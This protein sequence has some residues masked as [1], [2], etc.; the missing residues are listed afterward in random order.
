M[1]ENVRCMDCSKIIDLSNKKGME[2][3]PV[4]KKEEKIA[5]LN[6]LIKNNN[7]KNIHSCICAN[8]LHEYILLMKSKT[9]EEKKRHNNYMVSM[10]DLLLDISD[11][12]NI[13]GVLKV[14]LNE[15]EI[16]EL[17]KQN[18]KLKNERIEMEEIINK[19][20]QELKELRD[21]EENICVKINKILKEKEENKEINN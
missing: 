3:I 12:E 4:L 5:E 13:D 15:K 6:N 2:F 16:K 20:K 18:E 11:Q 19:S 21:E 14:I 8:C 17:C 10:K 7:Y 1:T 9:E